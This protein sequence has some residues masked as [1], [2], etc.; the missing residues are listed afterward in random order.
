V[1]VVTKR[2]LDRMDAQRAEIARQQRAVHAALDGGS[3]GR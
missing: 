2:I 1:V 3:Y